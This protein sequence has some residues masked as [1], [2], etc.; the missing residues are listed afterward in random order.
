MFELSPKGEL[1]ELLDK[2]VPNKEKAM[3]VRWLC[4]RKARKGRLVRIKDQGGH[5]NAVQR[6]H[7]AYTHEALHKLTQMKT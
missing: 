4:V 6:V 1:F 2:K 5:R 3:L 7:N